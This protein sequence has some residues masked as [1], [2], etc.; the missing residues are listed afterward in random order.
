MYYSYRQDW[1]SVLE[2]LSQSLHGEEMVCSMSSQLYHI[3]ETEDLEGN[4]QMH[5]HLY[6]ASYHRVTALGSAKRL[7]GSES[8]ES[9]IKTLVS[10]VDSA[11]DADQEVTKWLYVMRDNAPADFKEFIQTIISWQQYTENTLKMAQEQLRQMGYE[12]ENQDANSGY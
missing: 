2:L 5:E 10:C 3:P 8:H 4:R 7:Q 1:S 9:I 6:D 12:P 11:L